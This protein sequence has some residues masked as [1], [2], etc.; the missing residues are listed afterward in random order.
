M[1]TE[2]GIEIL[3]EEEYRELQKLGEFDLKT[4]SWIKTP[5]EIRKLG[6]ALFVIVVTIQSLFIIT[7]QNL[8]MPLADFVAQSGFSKL[9][10][11][12]R[13]V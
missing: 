6:G 8:I 7:A 2:M 4:S 11:I 13:L 3:T 5:S 10:P 1:A 9:H 12:S